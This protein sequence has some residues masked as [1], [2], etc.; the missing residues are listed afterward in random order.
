MNKKLEIKMKILKLYKKL[1]LNKNLSTFEIR[2]MYREY[3]KLS[4]CLGT[5]SPIFKEN[6]RKYKHINCYGY[7]LGL[8]Q[9]KI[10]Y[11]KYYKIECE[12][13]SHNLGIMA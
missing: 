12:R 8:S 7:A 6:F 9:P 4:I 3:L 11:N 5:N 2:N 1:L 10:F 13:M